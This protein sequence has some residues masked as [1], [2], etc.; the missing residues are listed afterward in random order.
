[1]KHLYYS[2]S[3]GI[4]FWITPNQ[5]D[6]KEVHLKIN[7]LTQR[8]TEFATAMQVPFNEVKVQLIYDSSKYKYMELYWVEDQRLKIDIEKDTFNHNDIRIFN[9]GLEWTVTKWIEC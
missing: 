9:I 1:M 7:E 5:N 3:E 2:P 4:L 6:H 8:C